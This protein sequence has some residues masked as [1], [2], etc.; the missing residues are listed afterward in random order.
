MRKYATLA[1]LMTIAVMTAVGCANASIIE[2]KAD[3]QQLDHDPIKTIVVWHTYSDQETRV[4]EEILIPEFERQYP[5]IRI[6]S[7]RQEYNQEYRA[8]LVARASANK[9]P[10]V[11]RMEYTWVPSF[12]DRELLYPLN[13]FPDFDAVAA[14]LLEQMLETGRYQ[15]RVFGLP[16]NINTKAAIYNKE[17]LQLTGVEPES[18]SLPAVM[19]AARKNGLR[20]GM[21]GLDMWSSLPYF[22]GLGGKLA[23]E[24]FTTTKGY[25]NSEESIGAMEMLV[26]LFQEGVLNPSLLTG[27]ADLWGDIRTGDKLFMIDEGPWY[28]SIL[29]H[30]KDV[31]QD[32]LQSTMP[33][34][35][36]SNRGY[37]SVIGGESLVLTKGS[38]YKEEAWIFIRWMLRKETQTHLFGA[39]LIP[40][41]MEAFQDAEQIQQE[42]PYIEAYME[43]I[44]HGF[45]RPPLPQWS[46][47][48]DIYKDSL[49][50][51]FV[52][53]KDVRATLD[54]ASEAMDQVL[55]SGNS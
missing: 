28:Y 53:G 51:I 8:A 32:V 24:T 27:G 46:K 5:H 18:A 36:P 40:T 17:L 44:E 7:V 43:G 41:N 11:V 30:S 49:E 13:E 34:S 21:S 50:D 22:F 38:R 55:N 10:D 2:N 37:G 45:F 54:A 1:V 33:V 19:E 47:V 42:H 16:L 31:E 3:V 12:A 39:G 14:P 9:R 26:K 29:L 52:N 35:F 4:F 6:E 20:I 15:G 48:E 25:F 23:D